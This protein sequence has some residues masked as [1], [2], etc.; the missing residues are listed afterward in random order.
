MPQMPLTP[1]FTSIL[2]MIG[3]TPILEFTKMNAGKCRLFGKMELANPAGSIK[4]RIGLSMIEAAEKDGRLNPKAEPRPTIVE[5]TAGNTGLGLALVAGQKGYALKVVM[6]DKMSQ[7]K[8]QHLRA[9][10]AEVILTR[11]DV[12]KGHPEYYQDLA[13]RLAKKIPN[14]LYVDQFNN[15][16]NPRAHYETTGPEIEEQMSS[17]GGVDAVVVGVGS[18]GTL[19][20]LAQYFNERAAKGAKP[21]KIVLADPAGSIL[22]PLKNEGK[23]IT[24]GSWLVEGMGEDF[25]PK[26]CDLDLVSE[27][28]SVTDG[29]AFH[30]ARDLLRIEGVLA[31]SST[32]CLVSAAMTYARR[33][34]QPMNVLTFVCDSGAKYLS[35]MFNDFWMIDNGFIERERFNDLRD[36]VAR[37]H[38]QREDHTLRSGD[39]IRQAIKRMQMYGVS[40]MVVMD[41]TDRV[42]GII[43]EGD[44]LLAV[45]HDSSGFDKP[46]SDFMTRRLETIV[47]EAPVSALVPIFRA[48]R[49]AIVV[50]R[51]GTYYGLITKIDMINYLRGQLVR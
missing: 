7:E 29:E 1:P 32:G 12:E 6:P 20:G 17:V 46:V 37:R 31:G 16:D 22:A 13:A 9:M 15:P 14:S 45:T 49:I 40:Q 28:I 38:Q 2:Q 11:S 35:K 33:Q 19:A 8:I 5:A 34:T 23:Q 26:F 41:E 27:A 44:I 48:D 18:S 25:I 36:L 10:G 21:V 50:G 47:P 30:A 3:R 51:D 4:D 39:P 24:P 43:D 42:A